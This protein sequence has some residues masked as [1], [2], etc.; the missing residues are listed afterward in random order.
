[1]QGRSAQERNYRSYE[2][3]N[4]MEFKNIDVDLYSLLMVPRNA[5]RKQIY[6]QYKK[7]S[8]ALHSDKHRGQANL[9]ENNDQDFIKLKKAYGYLNN[10]VTKL[11]Y[12]HYGLPGLIMYERE[13]DSFKEIGKQLS[14]LDGL[15]DIYK[16]SKFEWKKRQIEYRILLKS[17]MI[18]KKHVKL[19]SKAST[20]QSMFFQIDVSAKSFCNYFWNF[21]FVGQ[22][23]Q[24]MKLIR[25][26]YIQSSMDVTI[27]WLT[28][29][30]KESKHKTQ[31]QVISVNDMK[32]GLGTNIF[33]IV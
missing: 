30:M 8:L 21:Y 23:S 19:N 3:E 15:P 7:L 10:S 12:D 6:S 17:N 32:K 24:A 5:T 9:D 31:L 16:D 29:N 26:K 18:L 27:P 4:A 14:N 2:R 22:S 33:R 1:M 20:Q 28:T 25:Y 11:I 13:K